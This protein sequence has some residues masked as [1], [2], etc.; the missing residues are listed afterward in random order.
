M[1]Y[2]KYPALKAF[3]ERNDPIMAYNKCKKCGARIKLLTTNENKAKF[4]QAKEPVCNICV[5]ASLW[6]RTSLLITNKET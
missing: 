6:G 1:N 5:P 2:D 3:R 4:E